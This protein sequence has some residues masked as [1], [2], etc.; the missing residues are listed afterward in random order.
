[1][2]KEELCMVKARIFLK[3]KYEVY[4]SNFPDTAFTTAVPHVLKCR[5]VH[6]R[7]KSVMGGQFSKLPMNYIFGS[8]WPAE[9]LVT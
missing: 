2:L 4:V 7:I 3:T 9:C 6:A 8:A 5:L 1:M